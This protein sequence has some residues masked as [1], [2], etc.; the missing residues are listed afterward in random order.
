M[1]YATLSNDSLLGGFDAVSIGNTSQL[2]I[3]PIFKDNTI[4]F[5]R[6]DILR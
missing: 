6:T 4:R 2:R 5:V 3:S 1:E